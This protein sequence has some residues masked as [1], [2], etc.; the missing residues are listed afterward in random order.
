MIKILTPISHLS[1]NK[2]FLDTV[3]KYGKLE[4]RDISISNTKLYKY[5]IFHHFDFEITKFWSSLDRQ[6]IKQIILKFPNLIG[7]SFHMITNCKNY[8]IQNGKAIFIDGYLSDKEL[9]DNSSINVNWIKSNFKDLLILI[10][11]N[12]DLGEDTYK[13]VTDP[14]FITEIT[15][16]NDIF[17]LYDHAHAKISAHNQKISF[18]DYFH[19][20]PINKVKQ[21]HL[22]KPIIN[23]FETIDAHLPPDLNQI[24]FC[25][26]KFS[27]LDV[28]FTI[29]YYKSLNI[30]NK[31][32]DLLKKYILN[33]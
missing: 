1:K 5:I 15:I 20:L 32:L 27:N 21:V 23:K 13:T 12:N 11:N 31:K 8:K 10:E 22:S 18:N 25:I 14:D 26:S 33:F 4:S 2:N 28:F 7:I 9:K 30:L 24:K 16:L 17:F 3:I 6:K 19:R 29:E